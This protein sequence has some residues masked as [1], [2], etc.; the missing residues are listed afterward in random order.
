MGTITLCNLFLRCVFQ[1]RR[2]F[3]GISHSSRQSKRIFYENI[4]YAAYLTGAIIADYIIELL[5]LST[6][7]SIYSMILH[8]ADAIAGALLTEALGLDNLVIVDETTYRSSGSSPGPW[9]PIGP[10]PTPI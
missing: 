7:W 3:N 6:K 2:D 4:L 5:E 8:A 10:G 1:R 9:P